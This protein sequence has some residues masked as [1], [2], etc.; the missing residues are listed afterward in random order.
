MSEDKRVLNAIKQGQNFF[1]GHLCNDYIHLYKDILNKDLQLIFSSFHNE[2]LICFKKLNKILPIVCCS[3][4]VPSELSRQLLEV[5]EILEILEEQL[6]QTEFAFAIE[7]NYKKIFVKLQACLDKF[8]GG[9]LPAGTKK[10]NIYFEIPIFESLN[11]ILIDG[12][13]HCPLYPI[14]KGSYA[15]VYRFEDSKYHCFFALKRATNNLSEKELERFKQEF[16]IMK[17]FNSPYILKVYSLDE[18]KKQYVMEYAD[19]TLKKYIQQYNTKL[20]PKQRKNIGNQIIRAFTYIHSKKILHRD[21]SPTNILLKI[22][23]NELVVKISDFGLVKIENSD[24]TSNS[25]NVKGFF[26]DISDLNKVGFSNYKM[27]HE[28][29]ALSKILYFVATGKINSKNSSC[30]FLDKGTNADLKERYNNLENLQKDF[31]FFV[32]QCY[33]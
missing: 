16:E 24:F 25:T 14:G 3:E 31:I 12:L 29:F 22:Y 10:I 9:S 6:Q 23:E 11:T 5:I 28:I 15:E 17:N 21:I 7:A 1:K 13:N 32:N 18:N 20:T 26:N 27:H 8:L 2:I 4:G 19:T 33:S 30:R